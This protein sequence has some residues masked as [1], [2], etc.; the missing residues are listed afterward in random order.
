M[1]RIF[2]YGYFIAKED[3]QSF[4][5]HLSGRDIYFL[6]SSAKVK[7]SGNVIKLQQRIYRIKSSLILRYFLKKPEVDAGVRRLFRRDLVAYFSD[8]DDAKRPILKG[9]KLFGKPLVILLYCWFTGKRSYKILRCRNGRIA[10]GVLAFVN[11]PSK[12][13]LQE[14]LEFG[15]GRKIRS[16]WLKMRFAVGLNYFLD[17]IEKIQPG[18]GDLLLS[19]GS[20]YSGN[21]LIQRLFEEKNV[22]C[23]ILEYGEI[24]G[25]VSVNSEGVFGLSDIAADWSAFCTL[26]IDDGDRAK[27]QSILDEISFRDAASRG[28]GNGMFDIYQNMFNLNP[29]RKKVVYVN[30][31]EL[32]ASGHIFNSELFGPGLISPN[33]QLLLKSLQSFDSEEYM[34][35]YKDHPMTQRQSKA[36]AL[37]QKQFPGVVFANGLNMKTLLELADVVITFPSK[38]VMTSLM[39]QVKTIVVGGFTVPGENSKMG[40]YDCNAFR[41]TEI[42]D[43]PIDYSEY[44]DFVARMLKYKLIKYD[45][46]LFEDLNYDVEQRKLL[47]L[48]DLD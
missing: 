36:L 2:I 48:L 15:T 31:S 8:L 12:F 9:R 33:A 42:L 35:V 7:G 34:F 27:T 6:E 40:L 17:T 11:F 26:E 16:M 47:T 20:Q 46:I 37:S 43:Q 38:V 23:R 4:V 24:P 28:G 5:D 3:K 18:V 14:A 1:S 10:S 25:T 22:D 29:T 19:W 21:M 41:R 45:D 30:G 39:M 13:S 44:I 32:V